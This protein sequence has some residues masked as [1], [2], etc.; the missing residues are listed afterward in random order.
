MMLN[1][2]LR[3]S[4]TVA[5]QD[6]TDHKADLV[7]D[8]GGVG[9][10]GLA[11]AVLTL[12][13]AG[14]TFP[15]V[16]GAGAGSI[17]AALVAAL[18]AAQQPLSRLTGIMQTI[19]Y[20][21]LMNRVPH[22]DAQRGLYS[23]GAYLQDWLGKQLEHIGITKFSH[24][25][26]TDRG[27][28][29]SLRA[30]QHYSLVVCVSD[31]TRRTLARFPWD[32][33][34]YGLNPDNQLIVEACIPSVSLPLFV[35]PYELSAEAATADGVQYPAGQR[36]MADGELDDYPVGMFDRTDGRHSRWETIG[37]RLEAKQKVVP[38]T[39]DNGDLTAG[40]YDVLAAALNNSDRYYIGLEKARRTVVVDTGAISEA[41]FTI[42]ASQQAQLFKSGQ[43]AAN[44]FL[45]ANGAGI[46]AERRI[47]F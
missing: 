34:R 19:D 42:N 24:L 33:P 10:I 46:P 1:P 17:V 45:A 11:G 7:L 27:A 8:G 28:D 5:V 29:S 26:Y 15:R 3:D 9:G 31:I 37:I 22:G 2:F 18:N 25:R 43:D 36:T 41:D 44:T 32:Y 47:A 12:H 20:P 38:P 30:S 13:A 40:L 16:A 35:R 6:G 4:G 39:R 14:Y 23:G 21:S